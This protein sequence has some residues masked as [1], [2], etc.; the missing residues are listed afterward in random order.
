[1]WLQWCILSSYKGLL[2]PWRAEHILCTYPARVWEP[3]ITLDVLASSSAWAW[4]CCI[5][6]I[7]DVQEICTSTST[8]TRTGVLRQ[9]GCIIYIR[10]FVTHHIWLASVLGGLSHLFLNPQIALAALNNNGWHAT[11]WW[12]LHGSGT[13]HLVRHQIIAWPCVTVV[14]NHVKQS[15]GKSNPEMTW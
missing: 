3:C 11:P 10:L 6:R 2:L 8:S 4:A 9:S 5:G 13:L 15:Y 14:V 7:V 1:M 12:S